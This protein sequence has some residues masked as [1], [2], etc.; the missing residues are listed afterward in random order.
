MPI[1]RED[2]LKQ[3]RQVWQELGNI[4]T[5]NEGCILEVFLPFSIGTYN[6]DIWQWI[7]DEWDVSVYNLMFNKI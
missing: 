6:E 1:T 5:D 3:A 2:E 7:E 4:P